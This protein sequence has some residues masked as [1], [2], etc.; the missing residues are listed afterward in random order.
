[1][2]VQ[3][4]KNSDSTSPSY[5]RFNSS[6]T[7]TLL[8][9]GRTMDVIKEGAGEVPPVT[10]TPLSTTAAPMTTPAFDAL[11]RKIRLSG[12]LGT[13]PARVIEAQSNNFTHLE[14]LESLVN[15]E[16]TVREERSF[17]RRIK[18]AGI[19]EVKDL[20]D[21]NWSFNPL[22]PKNKLFDIAT[23]RFVAEKKNALL[24]GPPGVDRKSTRLNSSHSQ[25]SY[26][27]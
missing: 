4:Y 19:V 26:A 15:D 2:E 20:R 17:Q 8:V 25:I 27:V 23:A 1:M 14:F 22:L 6:L 21:M 5:N 11:M 18:Q 3:W 9:R 7:N 12:M 10:L 24:Y 16:I 13:L